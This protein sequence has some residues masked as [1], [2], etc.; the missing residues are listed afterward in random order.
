MTKPIHPTAL[1]RLSVLGE[2]CSRNSFEHGELKS[3][4]K[5]LS[6]QTYNIPGSK[7]VHLSAK[8]IENWYYAWLKQGIDRLVPK[9]RR[10]KGQCHINPELQELIISTKQESPS[11]SIPTVIKLLETQGKVARGELSHATVHRLL[12]KH[13]LSKR[14]VTPS[15]QIERRSFEALTACDIWYGDVMH[16]PTIYDGQRRVKSYL[17]SIFDDASRLVCHSKFCTDESAI[18][19]EHVLKEA[20]LK[21][22]L[23]V[24]L[25]IDNG[26]AYRAKTLQTICARLKIQLIYGRPYEPQSKGKL[27]RWHRTVREQ[28]LA[29]CNLDSIHSFNALNDRFWAWVERVYHQA[30][31]S[32]LPD[33]MTSLQR[34][35]QDLT[36]IQ[37]LG[38]LAD[39]LDDYFLHRIKRRVRK[40]G[41]VSWNN[42]LFE[43]PFEL[44]QQEVYLVVDPHSDSAR[45]VES[46][47][48]QYLGAVGELDKHNNLSRTRAR[49]QMPEQPAR[50]TSL[51]EIVYNQVKEDLDITEE[52]PS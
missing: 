46:L 19:I 30:S 43:V 48:Y 14:T 36:K 29:E 51:V 17:V 39:K 1:F 18:T 52:I 23:P 11:R 37:P 21:R 3:I 32:A 44:A 24:K 4:I 9:T 10:D 5:R 28:F 22:G 34:Y 31:Q 13:G 42:R 8:T 38:C 35:Q 47:E 45:H 15:N 26:P 7:R 25:I 40:D 16:G 41:T 49:P 6:Q 50:K 2:L 20:L 33:K 27:E 12:V